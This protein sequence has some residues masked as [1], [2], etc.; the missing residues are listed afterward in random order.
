MRR[1]SEHCIGDQSWEGHGRRGR[2][3]PETH[4]LQVCNRVVYGQPHLDERLSILC[5][6]AV[7]LHGRGANGFHRLALLCELG[8]SLSLRRAAVHVP[9][10]GCLRARKVN[11]KRG[12]KQRTRRWPMRAGPGL[13]EQKIPTS[14][15]S[16]REYGK[17]TRPRQPTLSRNLT[18]P[19]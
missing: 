16:R 11:R 13:V 10:R 2:K 18:Y 15:P 14:L 7:V 3:L 9:F 6:K 4:S 12:Q 5:R 19:S 8:L 17:R 1:G